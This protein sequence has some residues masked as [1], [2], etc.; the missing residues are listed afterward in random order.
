MTSF[1]GRQVSC[2]FR[3]V[4]SLQTPSS[5]RPLPSIC[6]FVCCAH[7][8]AQGRL[9]H[10]PRRNPRPRPPARPRRGQAKANSPPQPIGILQQAPGNRQIAW[11]N[12][13]Q[14]KSMTRQHL[15]KMPTTQP[16]CNRKRGL[17]KIAATRPVGEPCRL[18]NNHH[19]CVNWKID[20]L[21]TNTPSTARNS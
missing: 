19:A 2:V 20:K 16:K 8:G 10:R 14:H 3:G 9:H 21:W 17:A 7:A 6:G 11:A 1:A 4:R 15:R 5:L 12:N 13:R 18:A